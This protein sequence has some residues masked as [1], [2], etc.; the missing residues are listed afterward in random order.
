MVTN[1]ALFSLFFGVGADVALSGVVA[2][3]SEARPGVESRR[4]CAVDLFNIDS[5]SSINLLAG[6]MTR[7]DR[8]NFSVS[9][10]VVA[11][12]VVEASPL[13]RSSFSTRPDARAFA[14][15]DRTREA[16]NPVDSVSVRTSAA[17]GTSTRFSNE[18][19]SRRCEARGVRSSR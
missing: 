6:L 19:V 3:T 12:L 13:P 8:L 4:R 7:R 14:N 16:V 1:F 2:A 11:V 9:P 17:E 10:F 18:K 15:Q 5:C